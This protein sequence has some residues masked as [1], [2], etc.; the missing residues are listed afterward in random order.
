MLFLLRAITIH[1]GK[2]IGFNYKNNQ[3]CGKLAYF[4]LVNKFAKSILNYQ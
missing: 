2:K 1:N 4:Q 3:K